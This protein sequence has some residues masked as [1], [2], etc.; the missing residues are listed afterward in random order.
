MIVKIGSMSSLLLMNALN[1]NQMYQIL[2]LTWGTN[3]EDGVVKLL[4]KLGTEVIPHMQDS[5]RERLQ[6]ASYA[7]NKAWLYPESHFPVD[8][9]R[10]L[11]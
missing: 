11:L 1:S 3:K 10:F 6:A 2:E 5:S 4:K 8:K 9:C 7:E